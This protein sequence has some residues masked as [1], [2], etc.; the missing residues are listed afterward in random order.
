MIFIYMVLRLVFVQTYS[1][2][3]VQDLS[4]GAIRRC[5]SPCCHHFRLH[6]AI[7]PW[8]DPMRRLTDQAQL[9]VG[10]GG[11]VDWSVEVCLALGVEFWVLVD[12]V[13]VVFV[14]L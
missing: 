13:L 7:L 1:L 8:H 2:V 9:A 5:C 3:Q 10:L 4:L 12:M 11:L 14:P 6:L